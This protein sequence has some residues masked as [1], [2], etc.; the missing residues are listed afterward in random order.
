MSIHKEDI[1]IQ[2]QMLDDQ[3]NSWMQG[4][5]QTDDICVIGIRIKK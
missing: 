2:K 5:I 1:L 4:S 3:L